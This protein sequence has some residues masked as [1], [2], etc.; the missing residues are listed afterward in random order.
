MKRIDRL[1]LGEL[2]GPWLFGVAMFTLLLIAAT[3][4]GRIAD[5]VVQGVPGSSI[6]EITLLL[7]PAILVKTFAMAVLLAAL[8]AFGRLSGDS[9]IVALRAAGASVYRIVAPVAVFSLAIAGVAFIFNERFVP[10][11]AMRSTAIMNE[12]AK[13]I[14]GK[15]LQP[16]FYPIVQKGKLRAMIAARDFS[17]ASRTLHGVTIVSFGK[18]EEPSFYMYANELEYRDQQN[19]RMRGGGSITHAQA[20]TFVRLDGEAWPEQIPQL[21]ATPEELF[22]AKNNDN[23]NY[24]MADLQK[25]IREGRESGSLTREKIRNYEYG[26]WNKI[27]LPLAAFIF[28]V[29]GATLGIRSH[30]TGTATGFALAIGIIFT[31]FTLANFM[32]VWALGGV[33]PPYVASFSPIV[34]GLAFAAVI[35]WRRNS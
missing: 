15:A 8:L 12:I 28:G 21:T 25:L 24:S 1:V 29:L 34:L 13:T 5:Y 7:L 9:E 4:L 22:A 2:I 32:N 20:R 35:L 30:R 3:Y 27:A 31:Y 26:Y 10:A 18:N 33:I 19:W 11:A 17:L 23:D 16:T 14:K 6:A